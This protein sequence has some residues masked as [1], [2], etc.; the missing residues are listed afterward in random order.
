MSL[1][2]EQQGAGTDVVLV[3]GW[4]LHGG[5]WG[6][7]PA[8]LA[9][10][11]R[12]S[13]VD[14]P[15]HGRSRGVPFPE[16]LPRLAQSVAQHLPAS[17]TWIGWSLGG[18]VAMSVAL[19]SPA[20]VMRLVLVGSTP[21]FVQAPDWRGAMP[22][23]L[24]TQFAQELAGDYRATLQRFLS[25]QMGM[26]AAGRALL[27]TLR[28]E[29]FRHGE[30]DAAALIGGLAILR[31]TDLRPQLPRIACPTLIVH[32]EHDRLASASASEYLQAHMPDARRVCIDSA[33]H[34][35]FLS[36]PDQFRTLLQDF[37]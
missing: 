29:M 18:L 9:Q 30:P 14:L 20:H 13:V 11:H 6:D 17:A 7:L 34:A 15:G 32:G 19:Q 24:L 10:R 3:H 5:I 35:P 27:K 31:D 28:C 33:G 22:P 25:L 21:R 1:Y 4:G 8:Q 2:R 37:L 12:V 26:D 16:D 36:H 23:E